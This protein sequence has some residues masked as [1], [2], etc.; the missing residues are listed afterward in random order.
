MAERY[1]TVSELAELWRCSDKFVYNRLR[2]GELEGILLS[3][4]AGWRVSEE[5]RKNFELRLSNRVE[6]SRKTKPAY[7]S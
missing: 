6:T 4:S 1:F 2:S 3:T 7:I 5:A